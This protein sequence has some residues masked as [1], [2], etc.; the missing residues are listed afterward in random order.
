MAKMGC[1]LGEP[2]SVARQ[3]TEKG[4][5]FV[6]GMKNITEEK[7]KQ[8]TQVV[9]RDIDR[10]E[11]DLLEAGAE[12][13]SV[14]EDIVRVITAKSDFTAVKQYIE[15]RNYALDEA[16]ISWIAEN[17]LTLSEKDSEKLERLL[18][19]FDEDDDIDT[20]YHNAS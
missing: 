16:D 3:F 14:D 10:L 12:D 4:E 17:A 11:E 18:D 1:N 13:Y 15:Q 8:V 7:G 9:A 5:F 2:G 6:I 19:M 20:V